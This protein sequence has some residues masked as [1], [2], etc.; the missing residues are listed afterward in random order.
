MGRRNSRSCWRARGRGPRGTWPSGAAPGSNGGGG[1]GRGGAGAESRLPARGRAARAE[2]RAPGSV[3]EVA[4]IAIDARKW[5]DYG[6]GTYVRNLVRHLARLDKETTYFLLC[7]RADEA[8][9][10]DLAAALAR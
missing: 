10:R 6:I 9:L 1:A 3:S 8:T 4:R 2:G 7:A 5:H